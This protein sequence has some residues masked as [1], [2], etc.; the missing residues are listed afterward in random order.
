MKIFRIGLPVVAASILAVFTLIHQGDVSFAAVN[1]QRIRVCATDHNPARIEWAERDF[2]E[3][4][5]KKN[6][7]DEKRPGG[8][9]VTGGTINVYVHVVSAGP[10]AS[11]GNIPDQMI[12]D[13]IAVLNAAF[14]PTGWGFQL[15]APINRVVNAG[16][17]TGCYGSAGSAMKNA[18]HQGTA[19][20]LNM[21]TCSPSGGILGYATFP[22]DY[23]SAPGLDGVVLLDQSLPGGSVV[24]YNEGDTGTHEVGHWMGLLHT[25]TGG[26]TRN[27]DLVSDTPAEAGPAYEC[28]VGRDS[29]TGSRYGGVDPITNF[30]DYTD[31]SCMFQFS[32]GQDSRM[33]QQFSTYR[34]N[35]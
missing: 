32:A 21:Y 30:M 1:T 25:F 8:V 28:P 10:L 17:Y 15:A 26:C 22:S 20:D 23:N 12:L 24:P 29:C 19:D 4:K 3:K 35:Q 6:I 33:D 27:N 31:D 18:L 7:R 9:G 14:A 13:Q 16:W 5:A 34:F 2:E 11:Q